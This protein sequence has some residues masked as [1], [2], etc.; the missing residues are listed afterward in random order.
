MISVPQLPLKT[1][2]CKRM[3]PTHRIV[4]V[5]CAS[6]AFLSFEVYDRRKFLFMLICKNPC[7]RCYRLT[8]F[9]DLSAAWESRSGSSLSA[10]SILGPLDD[11]LPEFQ[12]PGQRL[13]LEV[14]P[15][16]DYAPDKT[17]PGQRSSQDFFKLKRMAEIRNSSNISCSG[18]IH[19]W[20]TFP[21]TWE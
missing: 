8:A 13:S 19:L 1:L 17:I 7:L 20:Q 10:D 2:L 6:N 18:A 14:G 12:L 21:G 3:L 16:E 9:C 11:F 5:E 15:V 4:W